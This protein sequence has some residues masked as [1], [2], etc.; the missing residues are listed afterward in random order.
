MFN[1]S[2]TVTGMVLASPM[3]LIFSLAF[4]LSCAARKEIF[5]LF[6]YEQY[7]VNSPIHLQMKLSVSC[8]HRNKGWPLERGGR[9]QVS[10]VSAITTA[11][12][13][14]LMGFYTLNHRYSCLPVHPIDLVLRKS[15][16]AKD[17]NCFNKSNNYR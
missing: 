14:S 10:C 5:A 8:S 6:I 1:Y 2:S 4:Q 17:L 12:P 13:V 7:Y 3:Q 15:L 11:L 16:F 9:V